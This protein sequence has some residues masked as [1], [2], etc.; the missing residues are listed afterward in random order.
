M[1]T[2]CPE[3]RARHEITAEDLRLSRG[4]MLCIDCGARFDALQRL[5]EQAESEFAETAAL[6]IA[7]QTP[8]TPV[9][10]G[11]GLVNLAL[12]LLFGWQVYFFEG[13]QLTQQPDVRGYL[14]A[15]CKT[16]GCRLPDYKN[17]DEISML[18]SDF[19]PAHDNRYT[20]SAVLSNQSDFAQPYPAIK[21]SL[22]NLN[23]QTLAERIF[24]PAEYLTAPAP[25]AADETVEITL[26]LVIPSAVGSI[27]GYTF[28][29]L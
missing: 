4:M 21:L 8:P 16:A 13:Y 19:Q 3:C 11:W 1:Y 22:N 26:N 17:L 2:Q 25:L 10:R 23:G 12:L 27:D 7:E 15:F 9:S 28:A 14:Q 6:T 20:F 24:N 18:D 5:S 29:L